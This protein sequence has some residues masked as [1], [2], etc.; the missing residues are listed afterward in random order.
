[1]AGTRAELYAPCH[2][3]GGPLLTMG[4]YGTPCCN[5]MALKT[6]PLS[7]HSASCTADAS[8]GA[9]VAQGLWEEAGCALPPSFAPALM[10]HLSSP[11]PGKAWLG[12]RLLW[13]P[14]FLSAAHGLCAGT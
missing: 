14:L 9:E 7:C 2:A 6:F 3:L 8:L 11:Y 4:M 10:E 13:L 5:K 1:M 12:G